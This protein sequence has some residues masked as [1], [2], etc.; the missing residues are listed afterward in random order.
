MLLSVEVT[1]QQTPSI[2]YRTTG[3]ILDL[4]FFL[5]PSPE[6]VIQQYTEVHYE[7]LISFHFT[8]DSSFVGY[9]PF[10]LSPILVSRVPSVSLGI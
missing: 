4:Y 10:I 9:W 7:E 3:G 6:Q 1:L 8:N 2:T 5:G